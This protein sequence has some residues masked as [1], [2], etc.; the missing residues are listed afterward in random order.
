[1]SYTSNTTSA[2]NPK[3]VLPKVQAYR[4]KMLVA[5]SIAD[6]RFSD[7]LASGDRIDFGYMTDVRVQT[8]TA[9]TLLDIDP[10]TVTADYLNVSTT[11]A[12]T[13]LIEEPQ[14]K[15]SEVKTLE[16]TLSF[17]CAHQLS[18]F[19]DQAVLNAGVTQA[20]NSLYSGATQILSGATAFDAFADAGAELDFANAGAG[21]RFAVID[22]AGAAKIEKNMVANGFANA[23]LTLRNGFRGS[24]GGFDVYVS[25]NLKSTV[26]LKLATLPTVGDTFT[27]AGVTWTFVADGT[28]T[29]PGEVS[30]GANAADAQAIVRAAINGTAEPNAGDYEDVSANN[31]RKLQNA[32]VSCAAFGGDLAVITGYGRLNPSETLTAAA[33][34]FSTQEVNNYLFGVYGAIALGLQQ[35]PKMKS[36]AIQG[37]LA[38]EYKMWQ[39]YGTDVF[40]RDTYR[41]SK[42]ANQVTAATV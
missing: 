34:G 17:Q 8:Y 41:L 27:I 6:T 20:A 16:S 35:A 2:L 15:Q 31:R 1:M 12:A 36:N 21:G 7:N 13:F 22:P 40:E 10:A 4:N 30:V 11:Q 42:M 29:N 33:D 18:S 5:K 28:A 3:K 32:Q 25:N 38:D 23:D 24:F 9:G 14:I 19:V 37:S 26:T 39:L